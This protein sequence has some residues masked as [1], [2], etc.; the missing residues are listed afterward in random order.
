[1]QRACSRRVWEWGEGGGRLSSSCKRRGAARCTAAGGC[2]GEAAAAETSMPVKANVSRPWTAG[3]AGG[4]P[5]HCSRIGNSCSG[6]DKAKHG[7][8]GTHGVPQQRQRM[9]NGR[10]SG[11]SGADG[12]LP[13]PDAAGGAVG[14]PKNEHWHGNGSDRRT[15][16]LRGGAAARSNWVF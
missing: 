16:R 12:S 2:G 1:M 4:N 5:A 9:K 13:V 10:H 3:E 7:N 11:G 6:I 14:E 15:S 8:A